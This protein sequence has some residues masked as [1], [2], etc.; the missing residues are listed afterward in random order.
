VKKIPTIFERDWA[1]DK[2]RVLDKP[3]PICD[4]VFAGEGNATVK[5]DGT[6]VMV[7]AGKR[8]KRREVKANQFVPPDFE[9]VSFDEETQ[10]NIGWVP[11]GDGPEDAVH[12]EARGGE[13]DGTYELIGPK[14][15]GNPERWRWHELIP[16]GMFRP[17]A[18]P[19][20]SFDG[21]REWLTGQDIEGLVFHHPD[22]RM[23]K[24]KLRDFGLKRTPRWAAALDTDAPSSEPTSGEG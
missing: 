4:W 1:G 22:G 8:F 2:S 12:R 3:N 17:N 14:V 11:V 19:P 23:A 16:H 7:R 13:R 15:Q 20:R 5:L 24:I 9:M 21:L 18:E 6:S 10:K